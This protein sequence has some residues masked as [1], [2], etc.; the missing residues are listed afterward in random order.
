MLTLIL[1]Q[2]LAANPESSL[3]WELSAGGTPLGTRTVT[4]KI[5]PGDHG[6]HRVVEAFTE[7]S[8]NIGPIGIQFRQRLTAHAEGTAP[9]SFHSVMDEGGRASE[10][11]G[12]WTPSGWVVSTNLAGRSR[13]AD[14]PPSR[15]DLST[16][17]LMDPES[18]VALANQGETV[19]ILSDIT[20][21]VQTGPLEKLG[22]SE[23]KIAGTPI[24]VEGYAWTSP[25]GRSVFYYSAEGYLV[26]YQTHVMGV[27]MQGV[28]KSAPPGGIDDFAVGIGRPKVEIL[29]L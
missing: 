11:Q 16:A 13:S 14:Y 27:G 5:L 29:P 23:V 22:P 7:L 4:V 25:E 2:A 3:T 19:R 28:L 8:G 12:R 26:K 20:G 18:R 1:A 10:I 15:I 24:P 6:T 17:D 9:A 21:E